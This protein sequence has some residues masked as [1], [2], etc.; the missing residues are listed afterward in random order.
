MAMIIST[1]VWIVQEAANP[2]L[3]TKTVFH[4]ITAT[5]DQFGFRQHVMS[6]LLFA[7]LGLVSR[8]R[9]CTGT[10]RSFSS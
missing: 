6:C 2:L 5:M 3:H 1:V 9:N 10:L 8:G 4:P 7:N